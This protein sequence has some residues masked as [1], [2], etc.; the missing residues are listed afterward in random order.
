V[1][2]NG[3]AD[4]ADFLSSQCQVDGLIA[5]HRN[6]CVLEDGAISAGYSLNIGQ[7][8]IIKYRKLRIS[9]ALSDTS[10]AGQARRDGNRS[11]LLAGSRE[12]MR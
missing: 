6:P 2:S 4:K 11:V 5:F 12:D 8:P 10:V 3:S 7:A 1:R 9:V